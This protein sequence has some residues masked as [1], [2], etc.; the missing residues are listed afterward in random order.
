MAR[1]SRTTIAVIT[2]AVL[3]TL[4]A[5]VASRHSGV[6]MPEKCLVAYREARTAVDT[7]VADMQRLA[8][9]EPTTPTCGQYRQFRRFQGRW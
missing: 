1:L 6:D 8:E 7:A 4:A 3:G 5:F 9:Q 2:V